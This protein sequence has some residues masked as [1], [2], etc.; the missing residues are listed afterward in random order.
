MEARVVREYERLLVHRRRFVLGEVVQCLKMI[1]ESLESLEVLV[2]DDMGDVASHLGVMTKQMPVFLGDTDLQV[3]HR[4]LT[5]FVSR[6]ELCHSEQVALEDSEKA[7]AKSISQVI[8][9]LKQQIV[10]FEV[11]VEAASPTASAIRHKREHL[12]SFLEE[13]TKLLTKSHS[14]QR[15]AFQVRK[16]E[17]LLE[18]QDA[19][20]NEALRDIKQIKHDLLAIESSATEMLARH[21]E[22]CRTIVVANAQVADDG[23]FNDSERQH[24][25]AFVQSMMQV[26]GGIFALT[27]TNEEADTFFR[28]LEFFEKAA[29]QDAFLVYSSALKL[30]FREQLDQELFRAYLDDWESKKNELSDLEDSEEYTAALERVSALK[31]DILRVQTL[32][33]HSQENEA[34]DNPLKSQLQEELRRVF[35][36]EGGELGVT[37]AVFA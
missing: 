37:L 11:A 28:Q 9:T 2:T 33:L 30:Q 13:A 35:V 15:T 31:R 25:Q 6:V 10:V 19:V 3:F 12:I 18:F 21:F 4:S 22:I 24:I 34:L 16:D 29:E 8:R 23:V 36:E 17:L 5:A 26:D 14:S 7:I 27:S 32:V 20:Q 1:S